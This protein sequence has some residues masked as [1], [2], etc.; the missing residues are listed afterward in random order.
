MVCWLG[1]VR[2]VRGATGAGVRRACS[3]WWSGRA[4]CLVGKKKLSEE[5]LAWEGSF[6][7]ACGEDVPRM[8]GV[9]FGKRCV[10][11][12]EVA[13]VREREEAENG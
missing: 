6:S 2:L 12:R 7:A 1:S 10:G 4:R 5:C 3:D 11:K 13:I 9:V 8:E